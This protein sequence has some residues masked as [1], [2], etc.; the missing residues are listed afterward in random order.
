VDQVVI[1]QHYLPRHPRGCIDHKGAKH[2]VTDRDSADG[3]YVK[4]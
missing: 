4:Q 3:V 1:G 2:L